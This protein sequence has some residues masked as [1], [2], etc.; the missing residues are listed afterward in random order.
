MEFVEFRQETSKLAEIGFAVEDEEADLN[1]VDETPDDVYAFPG[2]CPSC[3]H[4]CETKMVK[5]GIC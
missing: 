1:G 4:D 5:I 2:L 3:A